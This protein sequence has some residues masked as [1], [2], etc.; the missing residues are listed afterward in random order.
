MGEPIGVAV[1]TPIVRTVEVSDERA[2][3]G[4]LIFPHLD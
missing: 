1:V 2:R 4:R 3:K